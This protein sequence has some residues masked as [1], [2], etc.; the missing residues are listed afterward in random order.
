MWMDGE[1]G[2]GFDGKVK[3]GKVDSPSMGG[4]YAEAGQASVRPSDGSIMC[5]H[6]QYAPGLCTAQRW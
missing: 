2:E 5:S 1:D 4:H 6:V 3:H